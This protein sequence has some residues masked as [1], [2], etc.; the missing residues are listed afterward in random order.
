MEK[1]Q[2]LDYNQQIKELF[3]VFIIKV[4]KVLHHLRLRVMQSKLQCNKTICAH[5][6]EP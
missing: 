1:L 4:S 3:P 6:T 5:S 2:Y